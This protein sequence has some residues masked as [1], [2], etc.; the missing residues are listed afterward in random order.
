MCHAD[1]YQSLFL[2]K[3][4]NGFNFKQLQFIVQ[5]IFKKLTGIH[6]MKNSG[7]SKPPFVLAAFSYASYPD[8]YRAIHC[9]VLT[10]TRRDSPFHRILPVNAQRVTRTV[11]CALDGITVSIAS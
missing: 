9:P 4:L 5:R 8:G 1:C 11:V 6:L 2:V 10:C 7:R 3:A